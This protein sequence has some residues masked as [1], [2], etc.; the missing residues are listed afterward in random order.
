[1]WASATTPTTRRPGG[2]PRRRAVRRRRGR[3]ATPAAPASRSPPLRRTRSR[4]TSGRSGP[5]CRARRSSGTIPGGTAPAD[6]RLRA[7]RP[8]APWCG[9]SR[10]R[11]AAPRPRPT[12]LPASAAITPLQERAIPPRGS[13]RGGRSPSAINASSL[14]PTSCDAAW[15][16]PRPSSAAA[17]SSRTLMA[18]CTARNVERR[19]TLGRSDGCVRPRAGASPAARGRGWRR[20]R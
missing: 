3:P 10:C 12:G 4:R 14:N 15:A 1:M 20:R 19:R 6:R 13:G 17:I 16:R 18:T 7:R 2:R 9:T 11:A 5:G 8:V